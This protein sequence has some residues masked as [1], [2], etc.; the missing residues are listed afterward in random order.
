MFIMFYNNGANVHKI[1]LINIFF[2]QINAIVR[3]FFKKVSENTN[4]PLFMQILSLI[5]KHILNFKTQI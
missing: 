5:P 3:N 4:K 2:I 1:F